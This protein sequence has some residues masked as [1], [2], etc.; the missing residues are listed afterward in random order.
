MEYN[1]YRW[2]GFIGGFI[3]GCRIQSGETALMSKTKGTVL[4]S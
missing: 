3:G 2:L 4:E 1:I